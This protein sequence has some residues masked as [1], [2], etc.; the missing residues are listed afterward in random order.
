MRTQESRNNMYTKRACETL[1]YAPSYALMR[2]CILMHII[3]N[4][5]ACI[6]DTYSRESHMKMYENATVYITCNI[7]FS[8]IFTCDI[9]QE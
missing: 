9:F 4:M 7:D 6:Q 2:S 3:S 5:C 8:T 1:S